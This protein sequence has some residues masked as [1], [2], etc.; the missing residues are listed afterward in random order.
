MNRLLL[1]APWC[2]S[3]CVVAKIDAIIDQYDTF[4]STY[5]S[6]DS[7]GSTAGSDTDSST[8]GT[9][10]TTLAETIDTTGTAGAE[11]S[12]SGTDTSTSSLDT[13]SSS[14][15]PASFCGDGNVDGDEECDDMNDDPDDGCKL[16]THDRHIF[17]SSTEWQ[18]FTLQ[19]LFGADQRCRM[20]AGQALLPNAFT[21]RAWL[22]DSQNAAADRILHSKGRYTLVN[23]IVIAADWDALTSGFLENPINVTE[24][25]ETSIG[26][27]VWTGTLPSGQ[28][29]FGSSFCNDWDSDDDTQLGGSGIRNQTD[30]WWSFFD[31][32]DCG[33]EAALYC[34]EN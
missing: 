17:A 20:L 27:R 6:T 15:G 19:G 2:L 33:S 31:Q 24:K 21:Y 3:G 23:G 4:G 30:L 28:Q 18:G 9:D 34:I 29:A 1:L 11:A 32:D 8:T 14:T 25:S 5:G 12:M 7:S 13:S 16:C 26:S 10:S 22:S